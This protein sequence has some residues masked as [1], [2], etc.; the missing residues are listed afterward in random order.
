MENSLPEVRGG[1]ALLRRVA[2]DVL[3]LRTHVDRGA[4]PAFYLLDVGH[5]RNRLNEGTV[6]QLG[7]PKTLFG[8]LTLGNI[9]SSDDNTTDRRI[10]E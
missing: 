3:H 8:L 6:S 1:S 2:H 7:L 9:A 5:R 4:R 10:V